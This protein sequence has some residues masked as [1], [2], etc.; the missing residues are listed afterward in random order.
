[1]TRLR[2]SCGSS[3]E[4]LGEK[5]F[6]DGLRDYLKTFA[7]ANATWLDL[8]KILDDR[9]PEDFAAWSHVWVEQRGRPEIETALRRIRRGT[10]L[11][12]ILRNMTL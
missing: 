5:D 12:S 10:S 6:R 1:M 9:T 11:A 3:R 2:L 7:F 8:V 4:L